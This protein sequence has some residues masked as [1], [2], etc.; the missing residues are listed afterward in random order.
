M[1]TIIIE[2]EADAQSLLRKIIDE[3]CSEVDLLGSATDVKSGIA[4]INEV[5]PDFIFLDIQIIGG[6]G[7]DILDNFEE[8]NFDIIFTT[9]YEEYALKAFDYE[10]IQYLLKPYS[11]KN[12]IDAVNRLKKKKSDLKLIRKIL[13]SSNKEKLSNR[14]TIHS[15]EGIEFIDIDRIIRLEADRSYC[16]IYMEEGQKL[17]VSKPLR[18]LEE[19]LTLYTFFRSHESHLINLKKL[20]KYVNEDGGYLLMTDDSVVPLAR[21]RKAEI[22]KLL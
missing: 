3:Y 6:T 2:D 18:I 1:R 11:P 14:L 7:F 21:R 20:K 5:K 4:L 13:Q 15:N 8:I 9:A 19:E 10:A 17:T 16:S 22:L 12:V